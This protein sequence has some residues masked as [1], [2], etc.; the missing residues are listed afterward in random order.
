MRR[1]LG[2][3]FASSVLCA[4]TPVTS[5][6]AQEYEPGD[7]GMVMHTEVAPKYRQAYREAVEKL[8]E[9]AAAAGITDREWHFWG[10]DTGYMLYYPVA[11]FA[12]FDDPM[13]L[14]RQFDGTDGE[15]LRNEF[16]AAM[17]SIPQHTSTEIVETIPGLEYWPEGYDDIKVAHFHFE[18]LADGAS[19]EAWMDL[20][21]DFIAFLQRIGYPYG[22]RAYR[23]RIGDE[24]MIWVM[25]APGLS[26]FHSDAAWDD[27]VEAAGAQE[28]QEALNDRFRDIVGRWEHSDARY[29]EN[30]SYVPDGM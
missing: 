13:Q 24:R 14:W 19:E 18:W 4:L 9:A 25:F 12:Y 22:V 26:E 2:S 8:N 3:L 6:Q 17:Q 15:A 16:F 1:I 21:R 27:L 28:E 10:T 7:L 20:S 11:N 23:T 30:M 29:I 5:L